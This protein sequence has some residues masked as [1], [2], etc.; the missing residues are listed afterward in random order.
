MKRNMAEE[1]F[2]FPTGVRWRCVGTGRAWPEGTT[3]IYLEWENGEE[4]SF[5]TIHPDAEMFANKWSDDNQ[6]SED[7]SEPSWTD[8]Q[9]PEW[10][11]SGEWTR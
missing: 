5:T 1:K 3:T 11:T 6:W 2:E 8:E 10:L 7:D 4:A 9:L